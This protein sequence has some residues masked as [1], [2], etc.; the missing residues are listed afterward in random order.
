MWQRH[1]TTFEEGTPHRTNVYWEGGTPHILSRY[2]N[3][4]GDTAQIQ[5]G[6]YSARKSIWSVGG[7]VGGWWVG[8]SFRK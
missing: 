1:R 6:V 2:F 3:K 7:W 8:G 5:S 4:G